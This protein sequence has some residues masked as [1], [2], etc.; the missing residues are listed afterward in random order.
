MKFTHM[1][2]EKADEIIKVV[3]SFGNGKRVINEGPSRKE[4]NS[5]MTVKVATAVFLPV[6]MM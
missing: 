5:W 6:M 4:K 3:S 1:F 2:F